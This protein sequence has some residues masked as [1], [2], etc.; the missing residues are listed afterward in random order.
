MANS[1]VLV[2]FIKA[3]EGGYVNDPDDAGGAT[4]KGITYKEWV[5][6]FGDTQDR[7]MTMSD[8]DWGTIF[9]KE[10][11]DKA[12]ADQIKSQR[13][14]NAIVDWVF[15]SGKYYPEAD[16]QD[17]LIHSFAQ[18]IGEDG[19]FGPATIEAINNVDEETL[20][21]DIISKRLWFFDQCVASHPTNA[22]FLQGW[23]NRITHLQEF[24]KTLN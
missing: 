6:I 9:K 7:F 3:A 11:W 19:N 10:Y 8:E 12:L 20:Y 21:N 22:K 17:I 24:N 14:A 2:P 16:V 23:K 5:T 1:K 18:H 13:I 15:N 4:N